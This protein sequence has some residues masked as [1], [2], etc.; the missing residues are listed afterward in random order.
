MKTTR[1]SL[2]VRIKDPGNASAWHVFDEIYRPLLVRYAQSR[3][4]EHADAEDIA[5]RCMVTI[6]QHIGGFDYDPQKGKFKSWLRTLVNNRVRNFWRDRREQQGE[7]KDFRQLPDREQS[8]EHVFEQLWMQEHLWHC[9]RQIRAEVDETTFKAF[10]RYVIEQQ[11]IERV[12]EELSISADNVYTI[13]WRLTRK[14][15]TKLKELL[16]GQGHVN[17]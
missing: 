5:Q 9:L 4:L 8:P 16:D 14:V 2:L 13:K 17:G 7:T 6:H 15:G 1:A 11:P 10:Q 3:G 12:C